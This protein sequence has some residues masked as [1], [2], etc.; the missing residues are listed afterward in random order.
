MIDE[1]LECKETG[2]KK[3]IACNLSGHGFLD[4]FGYQKVLG[5]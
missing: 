3:V 2:E 4:I 5:L 1:A